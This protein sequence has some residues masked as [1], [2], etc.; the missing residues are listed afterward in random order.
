[1][2]VSAFVIE[3]LD[4]HRSSSM[5]FRIV[6]PSTKKELKARRQ[7]L[8]VC[9]SSERSSNF[10]IRSETLAVGLQYK[11][12][13]LIQVFNSCLDYPLFSE[14]MTELKTLGYWGFVD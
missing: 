9:L 6:H 8:V 11:D 10:G 2:F 7:A 3:N 14:A 5:G 13:E 4:H 1:M 12:S